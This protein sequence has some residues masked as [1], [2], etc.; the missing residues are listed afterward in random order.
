[1]SW[2]Q[3]MLRDIDQQVFLSK[4]LGCDAPLMQ[5]LECTQRSR[6]DWSHGDEDADGEFVRVEMLSEVSDVLDTN[7][8]FVAELDPNI[9]GLSD[10]LWLGFRGHRRVSYHHLLC[11]HCL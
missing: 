9:A 5:W 11:G 1:M 3:L 2:H 7:R 10:R 4:V 6:R 8:R